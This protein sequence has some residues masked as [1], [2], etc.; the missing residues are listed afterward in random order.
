MSIYLYLQNI[1][2]NEA[3]ILQD[4]TMHYGGDDTSI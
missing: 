4:D 2:Y 3:I 1:K